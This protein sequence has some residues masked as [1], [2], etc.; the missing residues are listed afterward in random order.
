MYSGL[1]FGTGTCIG[2]IVGGGFAQSSVQWRFAFYL[3]L[4]IGG[5][6]TPFYIFLLPPFD[7]RPGMP[8]NRRFR[9]FDYVRCF[10]AIIPI[11]FGGA[12]YAWNS[13]TII[14]LFVLGAVFTIV[15]FVQQQTSFLTS[16]DHRMFP[17]QFFKEKEYL[18]LFCLTPASNAAGFVTIYYIPL[19]FQFAKG[20]SPL[21]SAVKLLPLICLTSFTILL[22]GGL[23]GH[24]GY[25]QTWYIFGRA[26]ILVSGI[27]FCE[28]YILSFP[29]HSI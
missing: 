12:I 2:P 29:A 27:F 25:Y 24:F 11:N 21:G 22:N 6:F 20:D 3:N 18:L 23:M 5:L 14:V 15:F 7:P 10:L 16:P 17:M 8:Y 28:F 4:I 9:E 1:I 13:P 26:L 19:F